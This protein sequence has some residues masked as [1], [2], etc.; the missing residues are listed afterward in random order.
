[1]HSNLQ[2][3]RH[4]KPSTGS[5]FYLHTLPP[6]VHVNT[7]I[8]TWKHRRTESPAC[9]CT[10]TMNQVKERTRNRFMHIKGMRS[11]KATRKHIQLFCKPS[12]C[13]VLSCLPASCSH[14]PCWLFI[15]SLD[16]FSGAALLG[17][18]CSP[19][20]SLYPCSWL[21]PP[22]DNDNFLD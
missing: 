15:H 21:T 5:F 22:A 14:P 7:Q 8:A 20:R 13:S 12:S 3:D 17:L 19:V 11:K 6:Y 16:S 9:D 2:A 10:S 4:H 1:M 18:S